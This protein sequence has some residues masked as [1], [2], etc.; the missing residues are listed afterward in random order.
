MSSHEESGVLEIVTKSAVMNKLVTPSSASKG[1]ANGS[2][3]CCPATKVFGPST[4]WPTVNFKAFGLGVGSI[5]TA[6]DRD[7]TG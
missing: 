2:S 3:S 1:P 5:L 4:G 7:G 6:M